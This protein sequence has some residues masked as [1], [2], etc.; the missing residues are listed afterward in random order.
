M[1]ADH[2][3]L[4]N[5]IAAMVLGSEV[6]EARASL[7]AH[8]E[9]C[10]SCRAMAAR[11]GQATAVLP[12]A[13]EPIEP[14]ARLHGRVLAAVA[15]ASTGSAPPVRPSPAADRRRRPGRRPTLPSLRL[16]AAVAAAL[17]FLLGAA[18][19]TAIAHA[20]TSGPAGPSAGQQVERHRLVGTGSMAQVQ[21]SAVHLDRDGLTLV[22][23]KQ[24]P[25][26]QAGQVY[27]LW[28]ITTDGRAL[29]AATFAPDADGSRVV[30]LTQD[31]R[32][33]KAL[34][35]TVEPGPNGSPVPTQPPQ[36]SGSIA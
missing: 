27:E 12:L 10:P 15:A 9:A 35:V 32:G 25:P 34:A 33:T 8:L 24:M 19:G 29:P 18:A 3:G 23:F 5:A 26:P 28:L 36:L 7:L 30:L 16:G 2:E 31:L 13:S 4:E 21:A 1:A 11:L 20:R 6:P 14:P 22:D 17:A